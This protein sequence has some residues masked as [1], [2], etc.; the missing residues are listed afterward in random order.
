MERILGYIFYI[1]KYFYYKFVYLRY[2]NGVNVLEIYIN[3]N[4]KDLEI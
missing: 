1:V 4:F 3:G 2:S